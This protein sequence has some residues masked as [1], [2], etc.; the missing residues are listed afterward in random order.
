MDN[1]GNIII[2]DSKQRIEIVIN[3]VLNKKKEMLDFIC[4]FSKKIKIPRNLKKKKYSEAI[5]TSITVEDIFHCNERNRDKLS[6]LDQNKI[7]VVS[8][9]IIGYF[10]IEKYIIKLQ[11]KHLIL[12]RKST[13]E[14]IKKKSYLVPGEECSICFEAI[15]TRYSALIT[16]C[17]H[18]FHYKCIQKYI[19]SI[20]KNVRFDN[21]SC[22]CPLCR[23][24]I[25]DIYGIKDIYRNSYNNLDR[26]ENFWNNI[27]INYPHKCVSCLKN[28]GMNKL[29]YN[30]LNYRRL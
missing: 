15:N 18:C 24:E 27:E 3:F 16:D 29:C 2:I 26:L 28:L 19:Y 17:G 11:S 6:Y 22:L 23:Q 9:M 30:C 8:P 10:C 4:E 7:N 1:H 13:I 14:N 21:Y 12:C 20:K 25:G 5:N